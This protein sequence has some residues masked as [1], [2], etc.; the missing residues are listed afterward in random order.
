[1]S[2]AEE[3]YAATRRA[4]DDRL[5]EALHDLPPGPWTV[6]S[7]LAVNLRVGVAYRLWREE[8][9][10]ALAVWRERRRLARVEAGWV[11]ERTDTDGLD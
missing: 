9:D 11:V 8:A 7:N 2:T 10:E 6:E 1:M 4:S 3:D 5:D